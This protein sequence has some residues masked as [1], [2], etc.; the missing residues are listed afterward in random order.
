[1]FHGW[2]QLLIANLAGVP[3]VVYG[4]L[5]LIVFV[6]MFASLV[7]FKIQNFEFGVSYSYQILTPEKRALFLPVK[8]FAGKRLQNPKKG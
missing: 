7:A 3:S 6:K 4:L 2:F 8:E 5:G 1:M